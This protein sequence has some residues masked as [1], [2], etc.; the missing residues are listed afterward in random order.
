MTTELPLGMV[1]RPRIDLRCC[2]VADV[3]PTVRGARLVVMDPAWAEYDQRPGHSGAPDLHYPLLT[4]DVISQHIDRA[5]DCAAA[6]ARLALWG[7]WPLLPEILG[8]MQASRWKYKTGGSWHKIDCPPGVGYHW[9]GHSEF[10]LVGVKGSPGRA[11][12]TLRNAFES[13]RTEHSAKPGEWQEQWI[14]GWTNVGD[15][16]FDTYAGLGGVA[17]AAAE[18]H[19]TYVGAEIDPERHEA[20][21]VRLAGWAT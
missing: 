8:L 9:R 16:V 6:D 11:S 21:M 15:L 10:V 17:V 1:N 20:A 13:P 5:F 14:K 12:T 19:R 18:A 4:L 3:F 7:C 2:D